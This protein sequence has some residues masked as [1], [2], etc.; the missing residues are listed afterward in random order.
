MFIDKPSNRALENARRYFLAA[1]DHRGRPKGT[2]A[3]SVPTI[4]LR[5][6]RKLLSSSVSHTII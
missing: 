6:R 2:I 1:A 5:S 4:S 3:V